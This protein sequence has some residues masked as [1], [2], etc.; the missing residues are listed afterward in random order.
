MFGTNPIFSIS[1]TGFFSK[2]GKGK[3]N[4]KNSPIQSFSC[5]CIGQMVFIRKHFPLHKESFRDWRIAS[6][7]FTIPIKCFN[8]R[9]QKSKQ[10]R[11]LWNHFNIPWFPGFIKPGLKRSVQTKQYVVTFSRHGLNPVPLITFSSGGAKPHR[12]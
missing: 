5:G 12:I 8:E 6:V 9:L 3:K 7:H 10:P 11:F 4:Q 2:A 1:V